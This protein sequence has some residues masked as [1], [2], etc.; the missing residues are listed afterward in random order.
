MANS[1]GMRMNLFSWKGA[2]F[3]PAVVPL[4]LNHKH[5]VAQYGCGFGLTLNILIFDD[6]LTVEI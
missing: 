1:V 4:A 2:I 5:K 3:A 6:M